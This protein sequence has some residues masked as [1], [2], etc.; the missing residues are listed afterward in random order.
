MRSYI[1]PIR[2]GAFAEILVTQ[3]WN[4]GL[5]RPFRY[6]SLDDLLGGP[7]SISL[8]L[9]FRWSMTFKYWWTLDSRWGLTW[10]QIYLGCLDLFFFFWSTFLEIVCFIMWTETYFAA[11]FRFQLSSSSFSISCLFFNTYLHR[12]W[13]LPSQC[14]WAYVCPW[15]PSTSSPPSSPSSWWRSSS[16]LSSDLQ[17][18][19]PLFSC[20]LSGTLS[21][22]DDLKR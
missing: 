9:Y 18:S 17:T 19:Q 13:L 8:S 4:R 14:Q 2:S 6:S 5:Q 21:K 3:P 12:F 11:I 16:V 7:L 10:Y 1:G 15:D 20:F 22:D